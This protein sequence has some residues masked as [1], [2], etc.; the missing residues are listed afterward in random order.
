MGVRTKVGAL[1]DGQRSVIRYIK[2][3]F[4]D[5]VR[6]DGYEL[7]LGTPYSKVSIPKKPLKEVVFYL[8]LTVLIQFIVGTSSILSFIVTNILV[9]SS[10]VFS[11][12]AFNGR[13]LVDLP[14]LKQIKQ[15]LS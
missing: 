10:I 9:W 11:A 12:I 13:K 1:Q 8:F 4:L 5:G 6:Q 7:A 14:K 3:N 15:H 2:N